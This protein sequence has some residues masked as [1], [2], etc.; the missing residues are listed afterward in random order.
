MHRTG[1]SVSLTIRSLTRPGRGHWRALYPALLIAQ[2]VA[3]RRYLR[4]LRVRAGR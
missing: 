1:G 4:A 3:R 2:T